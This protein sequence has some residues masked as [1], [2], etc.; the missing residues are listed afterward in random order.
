MILIAS[1]PFKGTYTAVQ[2][3]MGMAR[4]LRRAGYRGPFRLMP[5]ADGGRGTLEVLSRVR[6][7]TWHQT[8]VRNPFGVTRTAKWLEWPGRTAVMESAEAIGWHTTPKSSLDPMRAASWGLG[9]LIRSVVDQGMKHLIIGLG[10]SVTV[11]GGTGLLEALGMELVDRGGSVMKAGGRAL[12]EVDGFYVSPQYLR[13]R[14]SIESL[15]VLCDVGAPLIGPMGAARRFGPQK[16]ASPAQVRALEHGMAR[17]GRILNQYKK[18]LLLPLDGGGGVGVDV[19]KIPGS[20]AA[21]GLGAACAA[22]LG[23]NI[24]SGGEWI[25]RSMEVEKWIKKADLVVTGEGRLDQQSLLGKAP[26]RLAMLAQKL[27]IPCLYLCGASAIP[28]RKIPQVV[29]VLELRKRLIDQA[30]QE[31]YSISSR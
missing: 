8:R 5:L 24:V 15:T 3:T 18:A 14:K 10:D 12:A 11:D 27:G 19:L 7:G 16:G 9:D 13:F 4:G 30:I 29:S 1:N 20:G 26:W 21:G 28:S 31:A 22:F 25:L 6:G 23:G 2:A 17:W